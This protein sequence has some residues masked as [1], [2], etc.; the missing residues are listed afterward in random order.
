MEW[1]EPVW[2]DL[3]P[4]VWH[5]DAFEASVVFYSGPTWFIKGRWRYHRTKR[6]RL[7]HHMRA[8]RLRGF[9]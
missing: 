4:I 1:Q 5:G 3:P 8:R 6:R 2:M 7:K 9:G